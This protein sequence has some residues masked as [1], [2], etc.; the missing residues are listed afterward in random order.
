MSKPQSHAAATRAARAAMAPRSD[1]SVPSIAAID[2]GFILGLITELLPLLMNCFK[3]DDGAQVQKYL[4]R[5][6]RTRGKH[7]DTFRKGT[8]RRAALQAK[9]AAEAEG[10]LLSWDQCEL[11][12]HASLHEAMVMDPQELSIVIHE[13]S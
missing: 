8:L 9:E 10:G 1:G 12:A 2:F 3:P 5:R 4:K 11:T 7:K 13:N 6:Y